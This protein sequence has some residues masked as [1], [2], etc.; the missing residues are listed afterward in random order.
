[1]FAN[2]PTNAWDYPEPG[3]FEVVASESEI[4]VLIYPAGLLGVFG[5]SHVI[6]TSDID[7]RIVIAEDPAASSVELTVQVESFEV[8]NDALRIEEGEAFRSK[9][10]DKDKRGTRENML[11]KKLLDSP[12]FGTVTV[13]SQQWTGTLPDILVTAEFTVRDQTNN[14]EFP[15]SVT[16]S[17]EQVV[18]SGSLGVTHRQLGLKPFK[19][20]FGSLRVR[21]EMEMKFRIT[22]RRNSE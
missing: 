3:V 14:L 22:A 16:T 7:G 21:D 6:S 15:A 20:A 13:R 19:A 1:M 5:H 4:R 8:D 12:N 9:V 17:D 11:G 2:L 10:S 18:V